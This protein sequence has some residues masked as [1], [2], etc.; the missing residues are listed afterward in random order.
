MFIDT[1][2]CDDEPQQYQQLVWHHQYCKSLANRQ[3][4]RANHSGF[5]LVLVIQ[6]AEDLP[7]T[8]QLRQAPVEPRQRQAARVPYSLTARM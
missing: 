7:A 5:R 8:F 6:A 4:E 3:P 2:R 1:H